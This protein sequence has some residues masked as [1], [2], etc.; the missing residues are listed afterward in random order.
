MAEMSFVGKSSG[1]RT[2]MLENG[3]G[4]SKM[5]VAI[6]GRSIYLNWN[7]IE[8]NSSF[9]YSLSI[10]FMGKPPLQ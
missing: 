9:T 6:D 8:S 4:M 7:R 10:D 3:T 5:A 1:Y 2:P